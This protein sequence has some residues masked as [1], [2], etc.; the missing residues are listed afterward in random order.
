MDSTPQK[1]LYRVDEA[2]HLL[3]LGRTT[4]FAELKSGRLRS[5]KVG[6]SRLIPAECIDEFVELLKR[7]A[8][9]EGDHPS[10]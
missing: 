10:L 4:L 8:E 6:R 2:A 7:E 3:G 9:R 5:L 1:R